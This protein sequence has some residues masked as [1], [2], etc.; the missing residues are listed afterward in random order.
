MTE[1]TQDT[2]R[3]DLLVFADPIFADPIVEVEVILPVLLGEQELSL[4]DAI[5]RLAEIQ[6]NER[7]LK[8]EKEKLRDTTKAT[9]MAHGIK[10]HTTPSGSSATVFDKVAATANKDY[11][12]SQLSEDQQLLA[13]P[14]K[15]SKGM[16]IT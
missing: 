6:A 1:E 16:K 10:T 8:K 14:I 4:D 15:T 12:L 9:L 11:I 5:D 2:W 13:Y 3:N 7:V